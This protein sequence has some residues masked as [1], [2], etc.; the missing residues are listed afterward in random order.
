MKNWFAILAWGVFFSPLLCFTQSDEGM[1]ISQIDG[2]RYVRKN[3]DENG[4]LKSYQSI[5]VG[6][7]S[8][9]VEKIEAKLT[10]IT[11]DEN[12]NMKGASQTI[13]NCDPAASQVMMAIFPFSGGAANKS[14]KIELP[15]NEKLYPEG[16]RGRNA[17]EDFTFRLEF[18][19]GAA[20]FFGTQSRVSFTERKVIPVEDGLFRISGKMALKAYVLGIKVSAFE[21]R[22]F[23][24]IKMGTGIVRQK[25][26]ED[27]GNYF[28]IEIKKQ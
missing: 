9:G 4:K 27:N 10:V 7:L 3:F 6:S 20:G 19:G 12:D 13:I 5:E 21:Y 17:L 28:T 1:L 14:L 8:T 11:Y 18:E 23:E 25:F 15:E 16:W 22:Y 24:D 26:T 2:N